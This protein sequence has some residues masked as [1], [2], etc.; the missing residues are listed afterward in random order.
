[1]AFPVLGLHRK[2]PTTKI[3]FL[4][5]RAQ[6]RSDSEEVIIDITSSS[7]ASSSSSSH[8]RPSTV[9]QHIE[10]QSH[11]FEGWHS[12]QWWWDFEINAYGMVRRIVG[13]NPA[14]SKLR[15]ICYCWKF[16]CFVFCSE[17]Q[18][19]WRGVRDTESFLDQVRKNWV[20]QYR[21]S[22]FETLPQNVK[23]PYAKK[24]Y[25]ERANAIPKWQ[26]VLPNSGEMVEVKRTVPRE[27][28]QGRQGMSKTKKIFVG[29]LPLS[30]NED[31]LS[32]YFSPYGKI[33]EA[34]LESVS[35]GVEK[36]KAFIAEVCFAGRLPFVVTFIINCFVEEFSSECS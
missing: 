30:I 24:A 6:N 17:S 29:G 19:K 18:I 28:I 1:M 23:L 3:P 10:D 15:C 16:C 14:G 25:V 35:R 26:G 31:D 32:E 2:S 5:D 22:Q 4:M 11:D 34:R 27:D 8:G 33:V 12:R 36:Q 9:S 21:Y 13:L 20:A 7:D